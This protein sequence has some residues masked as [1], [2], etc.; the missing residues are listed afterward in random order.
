MGCQPRSSRVLVLVAGASTEK[1]GPIQPKW[2]YADSAA[3]EGDR[4]VPGACQS[5]LGD[6]T[7]RN[8]VVVGPRLQDRPRRRGLHRKPESPRRIESVHGRPT[9]RAVTGVRRKSPSRGRPR[10]VVERIRW[11]PSPCTPRRQAARPRAHSVV[12]ERQP[13]L[14]PRSAEDPGGAACASVRVCPGRSHRIPPATTSGRSEPASVSPSAS[15]ARRSRSAHLANSLK[16]CWNAR[17]ITPL[18][19]PACLVRLSGTSRLPPCTSNSRLR[20]QLAQQ[21]LTWPARQPDGPLRM[22]SATTA[23]P[24]NPVAPVTNMPHF[25]ISSS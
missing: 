9:V 18:D 4:E 13:P 23:E 20:Q 12:G 3:T 21:S 11:S 1:R 25:S 7:H 6:R 10:S 24:M 5:R 14:P 19:L 17:W 15:I 16:S 22:S 2:P 8:T